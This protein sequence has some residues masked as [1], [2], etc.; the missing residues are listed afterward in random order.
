MDL[1]G[2]ELRRAFVTMYTR[3]NANLGQIIKD[4]RSELAEDNP[5]PTP[6]TPQLG[7]LD[8]SLVLKSKYFF[9]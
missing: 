6:P 9:S 2:H 3:G 1:L 4:L 7:S 8:P 5:G